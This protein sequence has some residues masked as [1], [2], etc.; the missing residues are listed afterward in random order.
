M[1]KKYSYDYKAV[2]IYRIFLCAERILLKHGGWTQWLMPVTPALWE[3]KAGRSPEVRGSKVSLGN[4]V[5][6]HL[7]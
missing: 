3:A 1:L 7:Y 6:P 4:I 5:K 2:I